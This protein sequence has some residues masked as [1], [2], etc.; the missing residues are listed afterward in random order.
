V[1]RTIQSWSFRSRSL[2]TGLALGLIVASGIGFAWEYY[3]SAPLH[4]AQFQ[5]PPPNAGERCPYEF[6]FLSGHVNIT[7]G[8]PYVILFSDTLYTSTAG[9]FYENG[10]Y[11]YGL[12]IPIN[13]ALYGA[14]STVNGTTY[15]SGTPLQELYHVTIRYFL[16]NYTNGTCTPRPNYIVPT[17][18]ESQT[19]DFAC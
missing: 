13:T 15:P 17:L 7:S 16:S 4:S 5:C 14:T 3:D 8:V 6:T 9:I 10:H 12:Y 11:G 2:L 18:S 19:Q 1:R